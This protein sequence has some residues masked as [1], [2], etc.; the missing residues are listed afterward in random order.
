MKRVPK[1][2]L[3]GFGI[4]AILIGGAAVVLLRPANDGRTPKERRQI[5]EACLS[6]LHS[7]L[8]NEVDL[9]PDD[10][11]VPDVIRA[12]TRFILSLPGVTQ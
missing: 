2:L 11:R 4:V 1:I 8:T 3:A 5:A 6:M 7:S 10:P 12:C 9:K